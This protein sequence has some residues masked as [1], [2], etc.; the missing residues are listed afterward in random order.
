MGATEGELES[1]RV[2]R[3]LREDIVLGRRAPGTKLVERDI[4][5]ELQVSRLPVREAI[6][7]LVSEGVVVTRPRKWAVVREYTLEDVRNFSEVRLMLETALFVLAAERHDDETLTHLHEIVEREEA[8]AREGDVLAARSA[9]A[10][11][12][13]YMVVLAGND[14]LA[15]LTETFV[16]RL[17]WIFGTYEDAGAMAASHRELFD[18]IASREA[19]EVRQL[20]EA[21]LEAGREATER[22]FLER[23]SRRSADPR[24]DDGDEDVAVGD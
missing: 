8:A 23:M 22:R 3:I 7:M 20:V 17:R 9:A 2:A 19:P 21:H 14:V 1:A 15:E 24:T 4:A 5:A 6:R 12:H 18:A 13:Q 16:T 11:F 10:A